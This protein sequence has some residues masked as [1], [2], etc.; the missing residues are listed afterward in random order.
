M[1]KSKDKQP[2]SGDTN[3]FKLFVIIS[4]IVLAIGVAGSSYLTFTLI[5]SQKEAELPTED[6]DTKELSLSEISKFDLGDTILVDI[7]SE[8]GYKHF[9]KAGL[10]IGVNNTSKKGFSEFTT[11]FED[12]ISAIR[13]AVIKTLRNQVYEDMIGIDAQESLGEEIKI[14]LNYL[15]DTD[16][17]VAVYFKEFFIQ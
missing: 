2:S 5:Q 14:T 1:A 10:S 17:I 13:D 9:M 4:I 8:S 12:N 11:L 6:G 16:L 3:G 7:N 15:M